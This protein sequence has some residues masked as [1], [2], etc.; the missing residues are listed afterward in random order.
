MR[1]VNTF[2]GSPV[3]RVED[4]RFLRGR[5][6]YVGDLDRPGQWHAAIGRSPVALEIEHL[7][8]VTNRHASAKGD[9]L[10]FEGTSTNCATVF[11]ARK[12]DVA[13]AFRSAAYT[14][15]ESFRVQRMTAMPMETRGLLAEWD[16]TAG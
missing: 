7:P 14:R 6:Q 2:I 16:A 12:G 1:S 13:S 5:G 3:E 11:T 8:A 15:R 10:L 4:L 9:V